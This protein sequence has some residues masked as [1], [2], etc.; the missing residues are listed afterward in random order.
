MKV[1][2]LSGLG[3]DKTVFQLLDLSFCEPVFIDWIKPLP[4]EQLQQYALRIK[5][6]CIPA[7]D[8]VIVGL[9]FGGM[10][11]TEI[12]TYYPNTRSII[13]SSSKTKNEIPALYRAGKYFP[14]YKWLP[15]KLQKTFMRFYEKRFGVRS[16]TGK[17]IYQNVIKQADI[18]F[19]RWAIHALLYWDNMEVPANIVHVHGTADK[20]LPY[21]NITCNYT[22]QNGGH[23]MVM[24]NAREISAIL[25]ELIVQYK[26]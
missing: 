25:Q 4:D 10:L 8:A 6:E 5:K 13:I 12:A 16:K 7:D 22:I 17:K 18:S 26:S 20:I 19:N 21:K 2:F 9:S 24:E 3:A 11:A 15:G 1:Y 23:L 14:L